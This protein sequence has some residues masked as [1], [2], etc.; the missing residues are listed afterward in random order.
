MKRR[1]LALGLTALSL[2]L[3]SAYAQTKWDLPTAY[4]ASNFH[5]ENIQ[6]FANDVDKSSGGKLKITVHPNASLFKAPE[7]K[8]AVQGGQAQ[9]GEILKTIQ[10]IA[11]QTN[12][13]ALNAT[14]EAARAGEAGKGFAVVAGEVKNLANQTAKAT[15]EI[16]SQI[17]AIQGSTQLAVT[18]VN[19][20]SKVIIEINQIAAMI[21]SAVEEQGA[22]TKEISRN[23]QQAAQGTQEVSSNITDV[24][25]GATETGS[26]SS[27][28]LSAAQTLSR[29]SNR[30]R[31]EVSNFLTSVR[32][33]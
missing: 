6:Q 21:A 15:E 8:R 25:R 14:I 32:A 4:P 9:I 10:K 30:L 23:V 19:E 13:L 5:T 27:Q 26:A 31:S 2:S 16:A 18:A 7:I 29:D 1:H 17:Q 33:A 3:S 24:Q 28:V 12:L 20:V 22:A 11:S